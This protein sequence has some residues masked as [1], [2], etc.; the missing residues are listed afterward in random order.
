M[1]DAVSLLLVEDDV[2]LLEIFARRLTRSGFCVT[3]CEDDAAALAA[4]AAQRYDVALVDRLLS[5]RDGLALARRLKE[6]QPALRLV[7]LSGCSDEESRQEAQRS[8]A[9]AF[10]TKPCSLHALETSLRR[11]S[12]LPST[13][14]S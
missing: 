9:C 13:A 1:T 3:A 10:L 6:I 14:G 12:E 5:R 8:G 4:A 2:E 11:A 7:V